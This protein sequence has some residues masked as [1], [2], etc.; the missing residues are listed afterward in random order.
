MKC[1]ARI[2]LVALCV[3]LAPAPAAR[4]E[5]YAVFFAGGNNDEDNWEIYY[6]EI[7]RHYKH[8]VNRWNY[9]PENVW[10]IFADGMNSYKDL[11]MW[12]PYDPENSDWS[13]VDD[14]HS[15]VLEASYDNTRDVLTG[16]QDLGPGDLFYFWSYDHGY[17]DTDVPSHHDE[18]G[19]SGWNQWENNDIDDDVFAGWVNPIGAG[20][21]AYVLGQCYSGGILEELQMINLPPGHRRFG[22]ASAT[23]QEP[24]Q[25]G[26]GFEGFNDAWCDGIENED[27]TFT[28]HL[29]VY[30][31]NDTDCATDGEGP[32]ADYSW[33]VQHPWMRGD[34]FFLPVSVWE[35]SG[36][37][38][39]STNWEDASNWS[40]W[41]EGGSVRVAFETAGQAI[42]DEQLT[43]AGYLTLNWAEELGGAA[44]VII[45]AGADFYCQ[46]ADIGKVGTEA[47][48]S[49]GSLVQNGG[50]A[51][52]DVELVLGDKPY[53]RGYYTLNGGNVYVHG[54]QG[55]DGEMVVGDEGYGYVAQ[56]GGNVY[57][58]YVPLRLGRETQ[59]D[60]WYELLG[61]QIEVSDVYVGYEGTGNFSQVS[62]SHNVS[63]TLHVGHADGSMGTYTQSGG[64]LVAQTIQIG[65]EDGSQGTFSMSGGMLNADNI[66]LGFE[67][68]SQAH[69]TVGSSG[70]PAVVL[71]TNRIR[72][73][74]HEGT[75]TFLVNDGAQVFASVIEV[76]DWGNGSLFQGGGTIQ[77]DA[78]IIGEFGGDDQ[79]ALYEHSGGTNN[80]YVNLFVGGSGSASAGPGRPPVGRYNL[81]GSGVLDIG[82]SLFIGDYGTG[83]FTHHES[84]VSVEGGLF[85]GSD[86]GTGTYTMP[87]SATTSPALT[88][89]GHAFVGSDGVGTFSQYNGTHTV[90]NNLYVGKDS[91]ADGT[92]ELQNDAVLDVGGDTYV[93]F[94]GSGEFQQTG[95]THLVAGNLDVGYVAGSDGAYVLTGGTLNV[96][97]GT[98]RVGLGD[99]GDFTLNGGTVI[100]DT[101]DIGTFG[102][103]GGS[104]AGT[105]RVNHMTGLEQQATIHG[106]LQLGRGG[107][108]GSGDLYLE[109]N[110]TLEVTGDLT[111]GHSASADLTVVGSSLTVPDVCAGSGLGAHGTVN[112]T[113]SILTANNIYLGAFGTAALDQ[114][115]GTT[116]VA[117][118]LMVAGGF[119][120]NA[121]YTLRS[122]SSILLAN[123]EIIGGAGIGT[124]AHSNGTNSVVDTLTVGSGATGNGTYHIQDG[125]VETATLVVGQNGIGQFTQGDGGGNTVTATTVR[126]GGNAD[127]EGTYELWDGQLHCTS[128][129]IG[130]AGTGTFHQSSDVTAINDVIVSSQVG[131]HGTYNLDAGTLSANR[132]RVGGGSGTDGTFHWSYGTLS[133]P[134]IQVWQGG[135]FNVNDRWDFDGALEVSGGTL[136]MAGGTCSLYLDA[137]GDGATL[138]IASGGSVNSWN[139]VVGNTQK[140]AVT[141]TGGSNTVAS[142]MLGNNPGAEGTYDFSGGVLTST[143]TDVGVFGTGTFTQLSGTFH[144][145]QSLNVGYSASTGTYHLQNGSVETEDLKI[146]VYGTGD[147]HYTGGVLLASSVEVG[148][149]GTMEVGVDWFRN[150]TLTINGGN[151]YTTGIGTAIGL[152]TG[153][154]G[155]EGGTGT[156]D[157]SDG[158][159]NA[160]TLC[161][162]YDGTGTVMQ[163]GGTVT[164]N[165]LWIGHQGPG[166]YTYE[167]GDLTMNGIL[168]RPGGTLMTATNWTYGGALHVDGGTVDLADGSLILDALADGALANLYSGTTQ[169]MEEYVGYAAKATVT[170]TGGDNLISGALYL[171]HEPGSEGIYHLEGGTLSAAEIYVGV[172]GSGQLRWTGGTLDTQF[173]AVGADGTFAMGL[174]QEYEGDLNC[175]DGGQVIVDIG[176][177]VT[178]SGI[179]GID[180]GA[181]F[182]KGGGG[183]LIIDGPQEHGPGASFDILGG[184]VNMNTDA[185]NGGYIDVSIL[186][187]NAV[188][189]FGCNQYL[190]TLAIDNGALVRLNGA[191]VVV[192][193]NLVM[194]GVPLGPTTLTPEPATLALLAAGGVGLLVRRRRRHAA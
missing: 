171:G 125:T 48:P 150:G 64:S 32:N 18:E 17:G 97:N 116:D 107:G 139:Q 154:T 161:V 33:N 53:S 38:G 108:S 73:G 101:F 89:A 104:G 179:F 79:D 30:A 183:T 88:V 60:G 65:Q 11:T 71:V 51:H 109:F 77:A 132:L 87:D 140:A 35:G 41:N 168:V 114:N 163:T 75:G 117:G 49:W 194:N 86:G 25:S 122:S 50:D 5:N 176:T 82:G 158:T 170:Q 93:G 91:G 36:A 142:L 157:I 59:G 155:D 3:L 145:G 21:H 148:P 6:D 151:V 84:T 81:S 124:F 102:T 98:I 100:A 126:L 16:L 130:D 15:T 112:L 52:F 137:P 99:T 57:L 127:G 14:K 76:G 90:G 26:E 115:G 192:V 74:D 61:G 178:L 123:N 56:F 174:T 181:A 12:W 68:G 118:D 23:H 159:L 7:L 193:K 22:C 69:F 175:P 10:V 92:Y 24:S 111:V 80:V 29:Y 2:M 62:G 96:H 67:A 177:E 63:G 9:K 129:I 70:D 28:Q 164:G 187:D 27:L 66:L 172:Q 94:V 162:G 46:T 120:P 138:T 167:G 121:S 141:H 54:G 85:L 185:G 143:Y 133:V 147:F 55:G 4:A 191:N 146:G 78:E 189:S 13:Y 105:L 188:L 72:I 156:L 110:R 83:D 8:V 165:L 1:L 31:Y 180:P 37:G 45:N 119:S 186:V 43:L 39:S 42:I 34:N 144:A 47:N 19:F 95:G 131:S 169:A 20:R 40:Y 149:G 103:L 153:G 44:N 106:S 135:T 166:E 190:D 173:I 160:T 184:T 58:T 134:T 113:T 152:G 136:D 128:L 182:S